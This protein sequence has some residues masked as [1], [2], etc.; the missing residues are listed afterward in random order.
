M[1]SFLQKKAKAYWK[2]R[3]CVTHVFTPLDNPSFVAGY[4]TLSADSIQ[5]DIS[6][7]KTERRVKTKR[8][9]MPHE[10]RLLHTYPAV[11]L[12]MLAKNT[13]FVEKG[14]GRDMIKAIKSIVLNDSGIYCCRYIIIDAINDP[15]IIKFYLDN[16]FE[17]LYESEEDEKVAMNDPDELTTRYMLYNLGAITD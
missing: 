3:L 6:M 7:G 4:F 10:K 5:I 2:Q 8:L 9:G 14:F 13:A 17:F 1:T 11:K 16:G 12:G 15:G